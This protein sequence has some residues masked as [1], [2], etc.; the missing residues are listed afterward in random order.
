MNEAIKQP[1]W[2][3]TLGAVTRI[4]YFCYGIQLSTGKS[5]DHLRGINAELHILFTEFRLI[6][7]LRF[8][9]LRNPREHACRVRQGNVPY[10]TIS[11][12]VKRL[13]RG[14]AYAVDAH[15]IAEA[16][17]FV[18]FGRAVFPAILCSMYAFSRERCDQCGIDSRKTAQ[19]QRLLNE[20]SEFALQ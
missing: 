17:Q 18:R 12:G 15:K 6:I 11:G 9:C 16:I 5:Q 8:V 7:T 13:C 3:N 1:S 10:T 19:R 14:C 20:A 2:C 4:E